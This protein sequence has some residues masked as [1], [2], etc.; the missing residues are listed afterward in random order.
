ML[1]SI[2]NSKNHSKDKSFPKLMRG[3]QTGAIYL[4]HKIDNWS[5]VID[6]TTLFKGKGPDEIGTRNKYPAVFF[7]E[8]E[9]SIT[10]SS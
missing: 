5:Q 8:Y 4:A 7:E 1:T 9:G 3:N 10:I 2:I 6:A